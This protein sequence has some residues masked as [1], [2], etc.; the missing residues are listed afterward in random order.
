M[1]DEVE[2]LARDLWDA[3]Q[4]TVGCPPGAR[5]VSWETICEGAG[6]ANA[7]GQRYYA[8]ALSEAAT[9]IAL[10]YRKVG[11]ESVIVPREPTAEIMMA[12]SANAEWLPNVSL[13]AVLERMMRSGTM[14]RAM[15]TASTPTKGETE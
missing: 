14:Y 13:S 9:L 12:I 7:A 10:G 2:E 4:A 6:S 11:P 15:I 5:G 8:M 3:W 1:T